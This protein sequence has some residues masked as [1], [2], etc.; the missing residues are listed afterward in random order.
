MNSSRLALL[1]ALLLV[2]FSSVLATAQTQT[3]P[4]PYKPVLDRLQAI[5]TIPLKDWASQPAAMAHCEDASASAGPSSAVAVNA[6]LTLPSCLRTKIE[7]PK[8]SSGY[9]LD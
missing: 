5:T 3:P 8:Q 6:D 4:D 1:L 9:S 2:A 7:L